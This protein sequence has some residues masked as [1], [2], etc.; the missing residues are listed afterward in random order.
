MAGLILRLLFVE[1]V[2]DTAL[3]GLSA[4]LIGVFPLSS[5]LFVLLVGEGNFDGEVGM[6]KAV[7]GVLGEAVVL[8]VRTDLTEAADEA[9]CGVD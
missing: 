1:G 5:V 9:A 4:A 6:G 2:G 3:V 7:V 8:V